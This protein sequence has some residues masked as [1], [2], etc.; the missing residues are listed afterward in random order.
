M[1]DKFKGKYAFI[2]CRLIEESS[3]APDGVIQDEMKKRLEVP[4]NIPWVEKVEGVRVLSAEEDRR[5]DIISDREIK[6]FLTPAMRRARKRDP[7]ADELR[8]FKEYLREE[9]GIVSLLMNN[10]ETFVYTELE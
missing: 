3:E 8:K 6:V 9:S 2:I 10:A 5:R 4:G 1:S 7:T